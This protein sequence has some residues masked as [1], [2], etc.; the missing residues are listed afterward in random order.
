MMTKNL[1]GPGGSAVAVLVSTVIAVAGCSIPASTPPPGIEQKIENASSRSDHEEL[2]S[3]YERQASTDLAAAARHK[4]YAATYLKNRS[5]RS[6][7]EAHAAL[8]RH[9]ESIAQAYE[10]AASGNLATAMLHRE[11]AAEAR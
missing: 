3:Q 11:L 6:G 1:R 4:R 8:A 2:A 7:A 9:C 5:P 10:Q